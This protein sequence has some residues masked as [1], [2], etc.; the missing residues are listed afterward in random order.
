MH[1]SLHILAIVSLLT[2]TSFAQSNENPS[3]PATESTSGGFTYGE[4]KA[5]YGVTEFQSGLKE[6]YESGNFGTSG[7]GL[8]SIAAYRKFESLGHLHFGIKYKALGAAASKGDDNRE[9]FF[10]F[11]GISLSTKYFPFS[12]SATEGLYLQGDYNFVTQFTQK[13]RKSAALEFDHQFAIGS[14]F[15]LGVG[16]HIPLSN[17]YGFV[18]SLEYD[19][20]SRQGEVQGIGDKQFRN[21]NIAVQVGLIF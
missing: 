17:R 13:Y 12:E 20:A 4:L 3:S 5:G 1:S 16:Y 2:F 9:M 7:G 10:N 19:M 6:R 15:T 21:S 8:F 18:A 14:S 11:H